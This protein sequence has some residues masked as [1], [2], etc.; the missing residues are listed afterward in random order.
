MSARRAA[1]Q[2][3][4]SSARLLALCVV[5]CSCLFVVR[6]SI[7]CALALESLSG[8]GVPV[9]NLVLIEYQGSSCKS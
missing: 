9:L 7:I 2:R 6:I 4:E 5:L 8:D 1:L 3:F